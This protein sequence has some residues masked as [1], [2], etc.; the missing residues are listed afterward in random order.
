MVKKVFGITVLAFMGIAAA[1]GNFSKAPV[2]A[3][4]EPIETVDIYGTKNYFNGNAGDWGGNLEKNLVEDEITFNRLNNSG[5][6]DNCWIS[7]DKELHAGSYIFT[8]KMRACAE[9]TNENIGFGFWAGPFDRIENTVLT[10]QLVAGEWR[11]VEARFTFDEAHAVEIDSIHMWNLLV[12]GHVDYYDMQLRQLFVGELGENLFKDVGFENLNLSEGDK[13]GWNVGHSGKI[14]CDDSQVLWT[15]E[16]E[17]ETYNQFLRLRTTEGHGGFADWFSFLNN[18]DGS[19]P[20]GIPAGEY[21]VEMDV[22]TNAAFNTNNVG[23]AFYSSAGARIERDLTPQV[24]AAPVGEW[25]HITYR[26][27]D[28]GVELTQAYADGVD[29]LQFWANTMDIEG[30]QLDIDNVSLRKIS[31]QVDERPEFDGGVYS[32][33]WVEA[34][35]ED[36]VIT[37]S[38]LHGYTDLVLKNGDYTLEADVDYT[39]AENVITIKKEFLA[40]FDDGVAEFTVS[41]TGGERQF[42]I[43]ITHIQEDL[44]NVAD[45]ELVETVFGG[46][47]MDLE[48]GHELSEDQ[49][50]Y[51]WGSVNLD[52]HGIIVEEGEGHALSLTQKAGSGHSF[53][54]A[55]VIYHPEKIVEHTIVTMA[56]DYKYNGANTDLGVNVCWVGSSN[57]SYHLINLNGSKPAKTQEPQ[58]KYRQWDISYEEKANGYTHVEVS[59]RIDAATVT[60]TNSI[61][62]LMQH[63][64]DAEQELRIQNVSLKKWVKSLGTINPTEA[65]FDKANQADVVTVVK[66]AEGLEF[67]ALAIDSKTT[68]VAEANYTVVPS[69]D[70]SMQI[71]IKKEYLATLANGEHTFYISSSENEDHEY[72]ELEF[73]VTISG[74]VAP[75]GGDDVTPTPTPGGDETPAEPAKKKGCGGSIIAASA[76]ISITA[77]AGFGL[78]ISKKRKDR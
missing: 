19:W 31:L 9:F 33:Q 36:V 34:D 3:K 61:R 23:F 37:V 13:T 78:L 1:A 20:A 17:N 66:F 12:D 70:G 63:N 48:V 40:D 39:F 45:Y 38:E 76:I 73:V 62:F 65:A 14:A 50:E 64:S 71:K 72:A 55:F 32:Y 77:L 60:A 16:G 30:W 75:S 69:N 25:T 46:D 41:T 8:A 57:V 29:S 15:K 26:Y 11:T 22:R 27:P 51:A 5:G 43:E 74:Q 67:Y 44:P 42:T 28:M 6:H 21:F 68:Y 4:A 10:S 47:F 35:N 24:K 54:S 58:A 2:Q 56:F 49:T 18:Y 52:D 53:S 7:L 59:M